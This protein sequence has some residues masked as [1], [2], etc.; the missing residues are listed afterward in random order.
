MSDWIDDRAREMRDSLAQ[1]RKL[2]SELSAEQL[3]WA[4]PD[5]GWSIGQ[6]FEHLV[7]IDTPYI[8]LIEHLLRSAPRGQSEWKP[9]LMGRMVTHAVQPTTSRKVKTG[10]G[11]RPGPQPRNGVIDDYIRVRERFLELLQQSKGVD[12]NR[13][14]MKSPVFGIFRYNLGDAWMI[15]T[16]HTER[17]LRQVERVR[18]NPGFPDRLKRS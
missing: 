16:R 8:Q 9:T 14:K 4:P 13:V 6:V 3:S 12:L 11:F 18:A 7:L 15:L 5:G 17:H 1:I 10:K 2:Q